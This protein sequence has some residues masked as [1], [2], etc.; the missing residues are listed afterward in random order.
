MS[1]SSTGLIILPGD[2]STSMFGTAFNGWHVDKP[3]ASRTAVSEEPLSFVQSEREV[4]PVLEQWLLAA[5]HGLLCAIVVSFVK[6]H[7]AVDPV[8]CRCSFVDPGSCG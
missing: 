2:L 1:F 6:P 7:L 3:C 4:I 5:L 8:I